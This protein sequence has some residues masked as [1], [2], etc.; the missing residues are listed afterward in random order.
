MKRIVGPDVNRRRRPPIKR[1]KFI[2]VIQ[3]H[4]DEVAVEIILPEI[5]NS[6]NFEFGRQVEFGILRQFDLAVSA[7]PEQ[8][9][10]IRRGMNQN[11]VSDVQTEFTR[12]HV[13]D[14]HLS[15]FQR[16]FSGENDLIHPQFIRGLRRIESDHDFRHKS[17][18]LLQK[19]RGNHRRQRLAA[20]FFH[21]LYDTFRLINHHR[22][23]FRA[24]LRM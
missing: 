9:C 11:F 24:D 15:A 7:F 18:V 12:D 17:I 13:T 22:T 2:G 10:N 20:R 19:N 21:K 4:E 6:G 3:I 5:G 16:I 8:L 1:E 23:V 14:N